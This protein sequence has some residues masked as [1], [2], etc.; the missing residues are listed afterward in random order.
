MAAFLLMEKRSVLPGG[1][2]RGRSA[3]FEAADATRDPVRV[4]P[5]R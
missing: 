3:A 4:R 5:A 1:R 2:L